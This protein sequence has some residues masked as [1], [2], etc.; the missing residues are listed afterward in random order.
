MKLLTKYILLIDIFGSKAHFTING[1]K[2]I[3][4]FL[5]HL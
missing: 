1:R 3:K 2:N 4:Q 5:V